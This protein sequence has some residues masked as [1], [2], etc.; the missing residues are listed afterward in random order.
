MTN[1]Y[2]PHRRR[3]LA[4]LAIVGIT[5]LGTSLIASAQESL[6][7]CERSELSGKRSEFSASLKD[8]DGRKTPFARV[9]VKPSKIKQKTI[10]FAPGIT[11]AD[12]VLFIPRLFQDAAQANKKY[13]W[14]K[15]STNL[16]IMYY[17]ING[18][19][20]KV[21]NLHMTLSGKT[22]LKAK[23]N[24][25]ATQ[26]GIGQKIGEIKK[27][28]AISFSDKYIEDPWPKLS[29]WLEDISTNGSMKIRISEEKNGPAGLAI[30]YKKKDIVRAI[31]QAEASLIDLE[32][33]FVA[34]KC[35]LVPASS[36]CFMTTA[37]CDVIGL[38]D[39][40]WEHN[41]LRTYR[42]CWLTKQAGGAA[43]IAQYYKSSPKIINRIAKSSHADR[44]WLKLYWQYIL[45]SAILVKL[46][47]NKSARKHYTAM[48]R[49]M[50]NIA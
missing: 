7:K 12:L 43:A 36:G 9:D 16:P 45:P 39:D 47:F 37:A 20:I 49:K 32:T 40:C 34:G 2:Q 24:Y 13:R 25:V 19:P 30:T 29:N 44:A 4:G 18:Q 27:Q 31:K 10:R 8:K 41:T 42:D 46:G 28:V 26:S 17:D 33:Q 50:A 21:I 38:A 48:M 22:A 3:L 14:S 15:M 5:P 35:Q 1:P 6:P 23:Y 11:E